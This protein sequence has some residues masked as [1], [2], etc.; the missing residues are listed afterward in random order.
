M[1]FCMYVLSFS[2]VGAMLRW[3]GYTILWYLSA[4]QFLGQ[5]GPFPSDVGS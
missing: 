4:Q 3:K 5:L 1:I 2:V